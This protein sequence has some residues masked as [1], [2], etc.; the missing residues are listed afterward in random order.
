MLY[1]HPPILRLKEAAY[2]AVSSV[3]FHIHHLM[4]VVNTSFPMILLDLFDRPHK[5][6]LSRNI[7][8]K[9]NNFLKVKIHHAVA[10]WSEQPLTFQI[11]LF[12]LSDNL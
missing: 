9:M 7:K 12:H 1:N 3:K 5:L 11:I 2:P 8:M 6:A 10:E 4:D